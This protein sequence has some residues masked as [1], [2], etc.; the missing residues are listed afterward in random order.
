MTQAAPVLARSRGPDG[1]RFTLWVADD[2]GA[3]DADSVE[4]LVSD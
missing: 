4:T 1:Y 2:G 3:V